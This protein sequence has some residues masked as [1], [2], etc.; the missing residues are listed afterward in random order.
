MVLL[1]AHVHL[2]KI[3]RLALVLLG[4]FTYYWFFSC[5]GSFLCM[6]MYD[7]EILCNSVCTFV[8]TW[9]LCTLPVFMYMYI[10]CSCTRCYCIIA[11]ARSYLLYQ[12]VGQGLI[13]EFI[14]SLYLIFCYDFLF[15]EYH[16]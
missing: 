7:Y 10:W 8:T 5:S 15:K 16:Y 11:C 9:F 4:V 1:Y 13:V 12:L 6:V 14:V 3:N 2:I